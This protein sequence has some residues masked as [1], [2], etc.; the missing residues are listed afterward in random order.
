[1]SIIRRKKGRMLAIAFACV[2]TLGGGMFGWLK[3]S[4][5]RDSALLT[6]DR[7][8]DIA[9]V[10]AFRSP[11][12]PNNLVL[13][14]TLAGFIPPGPVNSDLFFDPNVL[15]Q[16]KIDTN[17]DAVED[18]VIQA[19]VT[20]KPGHQVM[21]FRGPARPQ[22][23]GVVNRWLGGDDADDDDE[24]VSV[25]VSNKARAIIEREHGMTVFAGVRDDPFF[26][27][28]GQFRKVVAGQAS[29]FNNPGFD[30]F[31]GFNALAIVIELPISRLGKN[32]NINVWGTT[33]RP[34]S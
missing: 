21:H 30:T 23:T 27:D 6:S 32:P 1:M 2:A 11:A 34:R 7:A 14:L 33:S 29:S 8:A 4:D 16:I 13:S 17:N 31:K 25:R 9:D 15:Y 3:A 18:L 12:N 5:H 20:G 28:L 19:R 26:F 22:L 24:G 10:Y